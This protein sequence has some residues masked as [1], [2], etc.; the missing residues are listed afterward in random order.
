MSVDLAKIKRFVVSMFLVVQLGL[1]FGLSAWA[2]GVAV[3]INSAS[4]EEIAEVLKGVGEKKALRIIEFREAVGPIKSTDQLMEVKG[5]GEKTIASN[6][7][8]IEF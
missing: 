4:A 2:E 5:I 7:G 8:L 6:E 1:A 3:N